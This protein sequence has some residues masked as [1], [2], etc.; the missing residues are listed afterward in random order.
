MDIKMPV[1]NGFEAFKKIHAFN[2]TLPFIAQTAYAS[3]EDHA[4]IIQ[5]GFTAYVSKPLDKEKVFE[6]VDSIFSHD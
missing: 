3:A 2:P 4:K 5:A 6:L 1:L